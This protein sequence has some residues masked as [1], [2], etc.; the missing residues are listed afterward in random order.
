LF[1]ALLPRPVSHYHREMRTIWLLLAGAVLANAQWVKQESGTTASLR[2]ISAV[3]DTVVWASGS[4]G[5]ALRTTDGGKIWQAI[6]VPGAEALDFR[7]IRAFD[8]QAAFVMSVGSGDS[9]R[10]YK[11][12]D[13]GGH[14]ELVLQNKD[15][16]GFF[17]A[18][19]FWDRPRG[20][21]MGDPVDGHIFV[22]TT[23]DGG[24][25]WL[26]VD[27]AGIPA[28]RA[29]EGAFAASGTCLAVGAGGLAWIATGGTGG[30]RVYKSSDWG[31]NWKAVET[32]I[33]HDGDAS[34]IFSIAFRDAKHGVAVGGNYSK[35]AEDTDNSALTDDGGV[36]WRKAPS[37]PK[38]YRSAVAYIPGTDDIIATGTTG[39]DLSKDGGTS[40]V[41]VSGEAFNAM[42]FTGKTGWAVGPKGSI[43]GYSPT[44]LSM[45]R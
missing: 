43:G 5:T 27:A 23:A 35:P 19:A 13:G 8:G 29:G 17:D 18:I 9:S 6:K 36:T 1:D 24:M 2:G 10:I 26:P 3:S 15:P 14:W 45:I 21:V 22:A 38:G 34:G 44:I 30:G 4:N 41:H 39:T 33:R 42:S 28:A 25:T 12:S 20:I 11:T 37:T 32:P 31:L 7:A 16:K 40:W